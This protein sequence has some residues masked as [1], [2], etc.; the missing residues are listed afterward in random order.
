MSD[1]FAFTNVGHLATFINSV[2]QSHDMFCSQNQN[3]KPLLSLYD[4][5]QTV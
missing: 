3:K 4:A 2:A 1:I 5:T